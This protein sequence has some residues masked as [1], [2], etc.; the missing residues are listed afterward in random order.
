MMMMM[1]MIKDKKLETRIKDPNVCKSLLVEICSNV[2]TLIMKYKFN[3]KDA[4][5]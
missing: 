4:I 2:T 3:S 1:M 5:L